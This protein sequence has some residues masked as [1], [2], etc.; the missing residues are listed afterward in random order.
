[1]VSALLPLNA[2][3]QREPALVG[4]QADGDLRLQA[5]FLGE[6]GFPEPI[7]R[8]G[9]EMQRADVVEHLA[10]RAQP[11]VPGARRRQLLPPRLLRMDR[12][13]PRFRLVYLVFNTLFGLL[14]QAR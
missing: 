14:S 8:V 13:P 1:M 2:D 5:A 11:R 9:L 10:G 3:H 6:P 4:Q 12:Q 7:S